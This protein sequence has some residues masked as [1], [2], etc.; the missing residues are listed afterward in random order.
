MDAKFAQPDA[1]GAAAK[2]ADLEAGFAALDAHE[3]IARAITEWFPGEIAV[4]SSFGADSAVLLKLIADVDPSVPV[5]FSIRANIS[6]KRCNIATSSP[7]IW[8]SRT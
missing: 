1:A 5:A 6:A 2:A 8:G 4:V 7:T 3:L